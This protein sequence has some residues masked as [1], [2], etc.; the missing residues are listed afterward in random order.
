MGWTLIPFR[1]IVNKGCHLENLLLPSRPLSAVSPAP[2]APPSVSSSLFPPPPFAWF[3][4]RVRA[5]GHKQIKVKTDF[6]SQLIAPLLISLHSHLYDAFYLQILSVLL[7]LHLL[8]L[9]EK[10]VVWLA[11]PAAAAAPGAPAALP[12]AVLPMVPPLQFE[13]VVKG[14]L[15]L[16]LETEGRLDSWRGSKH[17]LLTTTFTDVSLYWLINKRVVF[18]HIFTEKVLI[19]D[20]ELSNSFISCRCNKSS[21]HLQPWFMNK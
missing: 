17:I 8:H 10:R 15:A 6:V 7:F 19:F 13:F 18:L 20:T 21:I 11:A 14:G 2:S 16:A 3:L 5:A 1:R 12:L 9:L 4:I